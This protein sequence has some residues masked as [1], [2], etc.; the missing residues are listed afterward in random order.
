MSATNKEFHG[1]CIESTCVAALIYLQNIGIVTVDDAN[2][3]ELKTCKRK[4]QAEEFWSSAL[5]ERAEALHCQLCSLTANNQGPQSKAKE[6]A[7]INSLKHQNTTQINQTMSS[8]VKPNND[9]PSFTSDSK[10]TCCTSSTHMSIYARFSY[11]LLAHRMTPR[12]KPHQPL[13]QRKA[14]GDLPFIFSIILAY[15]TFTTS[16]C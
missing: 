4:L 8:E 1:P 6:Q 16:L 14:I 5:Y 3:A 15:I 2:F 12:E 13:S 11:R 10:S 9:L 7:P